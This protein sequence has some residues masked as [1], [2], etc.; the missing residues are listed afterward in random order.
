LALQLE[1]IDFQFLQQIFNMGFLKYVDAVSVHPYRFTV[2]ETVLSD[3]SQLASMIPSGMPM[4][5]SE[6]GYSDSW[7]GMNRDLQARYLPRMWLSTIRSSV[8]P[9]IWYDFQ[10]GTDAGDDYGMMDSG[11]NPKPARQSA[12]VFVDQLSGCNFV[13]V[14][15]DDV[16]TVALLFGGAKTCVVVY[17]VNQAGEI[18]FPASQCFNAVDYLGNALPGECPKK[19]KITMNAD[20]GPSYLC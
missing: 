17:A 4:V 11:M 3:F 6:W 2:P 15:H 13:E 1:K 18:T 7:P 9:A 19:G 16:Q 14:L 8:S 20:T 5:S 10:D 12:G